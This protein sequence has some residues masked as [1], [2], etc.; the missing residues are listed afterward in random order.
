MVKVERKIT[1]GDVT[2]SILA[3]I[4]ASGLLAAAVVA[5]NVLKAFS[6]TGIIPHKRQTEVIARARNILIR[7]GCLKRNQQGFLALTHKGEAKLESY[8]LSDY[9]LLV[10][11]IWDKKW[12]VLIFDIPE[13]RKTLRDKVRATL[14]SI[15]FLRVQDSVWIFPYDCEELIALLKADFKIGKDLLYLIVEKIENDQ[16][17]RN[18]FNI[19]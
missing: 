18:W 8:F 15:G 13:Y 1:R 4:K 16:V 14:I 11:R 9:T 5:P 7:N 17:F 2:K 3:V 10:P 6:K 12:R 19:S